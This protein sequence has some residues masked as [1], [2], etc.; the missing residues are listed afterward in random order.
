MFLK[1]VLLSEYI[2][3]VLYRSYVYEER[4][5]D[6]TPVLIALSICVNA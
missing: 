2:L 5:L 6:L 1:V 3:Q 4:Y